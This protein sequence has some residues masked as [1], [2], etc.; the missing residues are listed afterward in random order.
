MTAGER[1]GGDWLGL[2]LALT[3]AAGTVLATPVTSWRVGVDEGAYLRW[4][5][6]IAHD[7]VSVLPTIVAEHLADP[8]SRAIAPAPIRVGVL[9]PDA[10]A[11]RLLGTTFPSLQRVS[12]AALLAL[13]VVVFVGVRAG[14]GGRTAIAVTL[15]LA[16]SPLQLGMARRALGDSLNGL[17]WTTALVLCIEALA[18]D[19]RR[20]WLVVGLVCASALLV[21]ELNVLLLAILLG[22]VLADAWWRRR[23]PTAWAVASVT[24]VPLLLASVVIVTAAG[25]VEPTRDTL[26]AMWAA[27]QQNEYVRNYGGGP[28]F[29][30]V[31]DFV[32][33]SPWTALLAVVWLGL[34]ATDPRPDFRQTAW[35]LVPVLFVVMMV[36]SVKFLRWALPLDVPIRLGAVLALERLIAARAGA[37]WVPAGLAVATIALVLADL[38]A[39]RTLFVQADIY[40]PSSTVLLLFQGFVPR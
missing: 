9:I 22:L 7:G 38:I 12:L 1:H 2:A 39:F 29:R 17:V 28:W 10:L 20:G 31:V 26:V 36:P 40:D 35:A 3:L 14:M 30:W 21:K 23:R 33:V 34:L 32:L 18:R 25:G 5:D 24:L 37:R 11:V 16:A 4:A 27:A 6:R 13:L 8:R 15:L 19:W